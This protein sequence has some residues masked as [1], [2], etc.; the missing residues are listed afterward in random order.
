VGLNERVERRLL[1]GLAL[2]GI[3]L[4]VGAEFLFLMDRMNTIFKF[5]HFV[6]LALAVSSI[7]L[8]WGAGGGKRWIRRL[9]GLCALSGVGLAA[10]GS[11]VNLWA[12]VPFQRVDGP[13]PTLNGQA[14]L[15]RFN[16]ADAQLIDWLRRNVSGLPTVLE[17]HGD[18]YGP[19][20]R[21][22]MHTGLPT[23]LG[24]EHH[25]RQR[26][27]SDVDVQR[28]KRDI[29]TMYLSTDIAQ[30]LRLMKRYRISFVVVSS[31]ERS[32][33]PGPGLQK[34]EARPDFFEVV[35]RTAG[36][37]VYRVVLPPGGVVDGVR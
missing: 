22:A 1:G 18:S 37:A 3:Y 27:A 31:L 32:T 36:G 6:W 9:G 12:M 10:F 2:S 24:W 14:Y 35:K 33:Y 29:A 13:R 34:F 19:Y 30:T 20:T 28:R 8:M 7:G 26:G 25:V 16:P 5:Y 21:I 11:V 4:A 15:E 17:A 23:V